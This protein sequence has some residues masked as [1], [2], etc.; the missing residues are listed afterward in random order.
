[1]ISPDD[2]EQDGPVDRAQLR[3]GAMGLLARRE[4][5]HRELSH[6]LLKR[7]WPADDV[8]SVIDELA[9]DNLQSDERF[10]ESFVRQRIEKAYGPVRIRAEL[11]ERGID[12][13]QIARALDAESPDW[14]AIAADW[15]E[16]RY[17]DEPPGDLREKS[18]RQQALARRGFDHAVVRE[19]TG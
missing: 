7:G 16:K 2:N 19:L 18:R 13:A 12:R 9:E 3:E 11:S 6:K 10:A 5:S 1:L 4:H 8:E 17:G 14:L 15:Y